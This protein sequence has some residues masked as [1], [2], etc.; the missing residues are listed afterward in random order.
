MSASSQAMDDGVSV[1]QGNNKM[2]GK[3]DMFY[4]ESFNQ[5][6][7]ILSQVYVSCFTIL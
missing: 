5:L 6:R 4:K 7:K 2:L 1:V 3:M